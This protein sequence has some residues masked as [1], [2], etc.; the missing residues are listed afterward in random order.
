M[1]LSGLFGTAIGQD[2]AGG[3]GGGGVSGSQ[4]QVLSLSISTPPGAP[5]VGDR[6]IVGPAATGVWTGLEDDIVEWAGAAWTN[7]TPSVGWFVFVVDEGEWFTWTGAS[8]AKDSFHDHA[9][10]GASHL[11]STLAEGLSVGAIGE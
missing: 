7:E 5:N 10:G 1:S 9:I 6:Y 2:A 8:W 3:G 11:A 4:E